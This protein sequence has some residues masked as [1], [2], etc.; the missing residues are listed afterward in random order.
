LT[1]NC[2]IYP[3]GFVRIAVPSGCKL[4]VESFPNPGD[5][6]PGDALRREIEG[7]VVLEFNVQRGGGSISAVRVVESSG[8]EDFDEAA[9]RMSGLIRAHSPCDNQRYNLKIRFV[10]QRGPRGTDGLAVEKPG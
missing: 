10:I 5:F 7:N 8:S 6:Y 2:E 1:A 3:P 4:S 9:L